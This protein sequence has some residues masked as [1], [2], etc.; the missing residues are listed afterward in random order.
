MQT[1]FYLPPFTTKLLNAYQKANEAP[2]KFAT[3]VKEHGDEM[4]KK[5]SQQSK[6]LVDNIA[7]LFSQMIF[8][9][10]KYVDPTNV[11]KSLTDDFGNQVNVGE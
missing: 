4:V 2:G 6:L 10:R 3:P 1:Y 11:L 8:A 9:N 5:R 7:R